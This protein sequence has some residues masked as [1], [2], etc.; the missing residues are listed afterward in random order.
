M[1]RGYRIGAV[2]KLTGISTDTICAWERRYAVVGLNRDENN[3]RYY[4][5]AH[6]N[7]LISVKRLLDAGHAIGMVCR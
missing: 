7:K 5:E 6:I 1:N 4:T 2:A 3:N